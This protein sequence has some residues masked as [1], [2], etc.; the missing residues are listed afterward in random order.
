[1]GG[2]WSYIFREQERSAFDRS[3]LG[4]LAIIRAYCNVLTT[5]IN[6]NIQVACGY[7]DSRSGAFN[8]GLHCVVAKPIDQANCVFARS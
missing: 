3:L 2:G 4:V 5:Q 7:L 6:R 1:M 8:L